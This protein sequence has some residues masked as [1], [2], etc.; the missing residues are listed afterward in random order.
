[1]ADKSSAISLDEAR[2]R[3]FVIDWPAHPLGEG[4]PYSTSP[5]RNAPSDGVRRFD[6]VELDEWIPECAGFLRT[7]GHIVPVFAGVDRE[8]APARRQRAAGS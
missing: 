1:M 3:G 6:G 4:A 8:E 2:K 7:T 5:Y